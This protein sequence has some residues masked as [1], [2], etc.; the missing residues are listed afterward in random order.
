MAP[1]VG[2]PSLEV[3]LRFEFSGMTAKN[4]LLKAATTECLSTWDPQD[5]PKRGIPTPEVIRVY[6]RWARGGY[7]MI[8][9]GNIMLEYDQLEGAGNIIIP[10]EAPFSGQRFIAL[11]ELVT[12]AKQHGS[13][14]IAQLSHPGRQVPQ[15]IQPHPI[16]ASAIQ[17]QDNDMAMPCG[18]P[19]AMENE[20][21][22]RVTSGFA[23]AAHYCYEAGFDG[24]ELHAAQ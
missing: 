8:V 24:I 11:A 16:S 21:F 4:R 5:L 13:L 19:R 22:Q 7:G 1:A 6:E 12:A 15:N 3:P 17:L 9:S 20:D 14:F 2:I 18:Q 10:P 23:H